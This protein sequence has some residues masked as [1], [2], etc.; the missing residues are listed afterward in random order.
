MPEGTASEKIALV[1]G[2]GGAKAAFQLGAI[3]YIEEVIKKKSPGFNYNTIAG[4][5][6]GA[7][8]AVV[9]AMEN[10]SYTTKH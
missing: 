7:P 3:K 6:A 10:N 5:S 2:G 4:V 9:L 1:L 8:N